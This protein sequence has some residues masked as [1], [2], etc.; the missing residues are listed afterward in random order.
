MLKKKIEQAFNDQINA[1]LASAYLYLSMS[2]YLESVNLGGMANWMRVQAQEE[3]AHAMKFFA[4]VNERGGRVLLGPIE[5]PA[6][7][8]DSPKAVF[9][10]VYTHECKVTG[11]IN[12]LVDLAQAESDHAAN[13]FLQWFV[14]EQVEEEASADELAKKLEMVDRAP[15]GMFF[16]DREL[17]ERVFKMPGEGA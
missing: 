17:G 2:A 7:T 9:E 3:T 6:E 4:F 12:K 15:G 5:K 1:E 8:W 11:M 16:L 13:A 14:N 10:A